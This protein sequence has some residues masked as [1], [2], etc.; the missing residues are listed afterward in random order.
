MVV[1]SHHRKLCWAVSASALNQS[2]LPKQLGGNGTEKFIFLAPRLM[3]WSY[4]R[5]PDLIR[6]GGKRHKF[7]TNHHTPTAPQ[8]QLRE[9]GWERLK[10]IE[11][12]SKLK[13]SSSMKHITTL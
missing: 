12:F 5:P 3:H 6:G 1:F 7:F 2:P 9:G 4:H 13:I 8:T 10:L 11:L